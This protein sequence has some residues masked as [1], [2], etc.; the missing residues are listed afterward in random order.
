VGPRAVLD[1]VVKRKIP[2]APLESNSINYK[3][4][5]FEMFFI[6][7][8][9]TLNFWSP[10]RSRDTFLHPYQKTSNTIPLFCI[11]FIKYSEIND[12][13]RFTNIVVI[14]LNFQVE[15]FCI[16]MSCSVV[17][18][19]TSEQLVSCRN[20]T[21]HYNPKDF[22]SNIHSLESCKTFSNLLAKALFFSSCP[23]GTFEVFTVFK[24]ILSLAIFS[25][26]LC[27]ES[28]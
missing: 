19:W 6:L 10:V 22:D 26:L 15:F 11:F 14:F 24:I 7:V 28:C 23:S 13:K 16:V 5:H 2:I 12:N 21:R 1:A 20:T 3:V 25:L 17:P 9:L 18:K 8:F 4:P 27:Y